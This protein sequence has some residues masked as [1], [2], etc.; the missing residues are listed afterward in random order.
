[1]T[2]VALVIFASLATYFNFPGFFPIGMVLMMVYS[3]VVIKKIYSDAARGAGTL[4]LAFVLIALM[5]AFRTIDLKIAYEKA[6][7][8]D[9]LISLVEMTI[10]LRIAALMVLLLVFTYII[11]RLKSKKQPVPGYERTE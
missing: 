10:V 2:L 6:T 9:V 3:W 1:M 4:S 11:L 8:A 7:D 5:S